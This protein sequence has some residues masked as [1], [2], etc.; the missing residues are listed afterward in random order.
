MRVAIFRQCEGL[1]LEE[2]MGGLN[3]T[4]S[5]VMPARFSSGTWDVIWLKSIGTREPV[6]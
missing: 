4:A 1:T 2:S 3:E 6:I 5:I